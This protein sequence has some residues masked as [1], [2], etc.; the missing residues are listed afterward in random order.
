MFTEIAYAELK[1]KLG[2]VD[3]ARMGAKTSGILN[4]LFTTGMVKT[5][6]KGQCRI[7]NEALDNIPLMTGEPS[8]GD[9]VA[10]VNTGV[11]LLVDFTDEKKMAICAKIE[12]D[13]SFVYTLPKFT[14]ASEP[15][16]LASSFNKFPVQ[17]IFTLRHSNF[18]MEEVTNRYMLF[19]SIWSEIMKVRNGQPILERS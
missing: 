9:V 19:K 15:N 14:I 3:E 6:G 4:Y 5:I 10:V 2:A 8:V 1:R 7:S 11:Y 13:E 18:K 16:D 17:N 12:Y